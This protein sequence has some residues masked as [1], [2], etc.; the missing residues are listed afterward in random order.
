MNFNFYQAEYKKYGYTLQI[1]QNNNKWCLF[2]KDSEKLHTTSITIDNL[3]ST[4]DL[5]IED[6]AYKFLQERYCSIEYI[7]GQYMCSLDPDSEEVKFVTIEE[8]IKDYKEQIKELKKENLITDLLAITPL[9][10]TGNNYYG[11]NLKK[12]F[13]DIEKE[14]KKLL[15]RY[16]S[17][18]LYCNKNRDSMLF[19]DSETLIVYDVLN[20]ANLYQIAESEAK[21]LIADLKNKTNNYFKV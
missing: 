3:E 17:C 9:V 14:L 12:S 1:D 10:K 7:S 15:D 6:D 20:D 8:S 13:K 16:N 21:Q 5:L 4:L 18:E 2:S 19:F 11:L